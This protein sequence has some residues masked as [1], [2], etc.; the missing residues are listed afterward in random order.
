MERDYYF[1][2]K[3][4]EGE[5]SVAPIITQEQRTLFFDTISSIGTEDVYSSILDGSLFGN[6]GKHPNGAKLTPIR[7]LFDKNGITSDIVIELV[8]EAR[9][10]KLDEFFKAVIS[11]F[12]GDEATEILK[13]FFR[14]DCDTVYGMSNDLRDERG[15]DF[16]HELDWLGLIEPSEVAETVVWRAVRDGVEMIH[17][18]KA[19]HT[20]EEKV[21]IQPGPSEDARAIDAIFAQYGHSLDLSEEVAEEYVYFDVDSYNE[22]VFDAIYTNE[23]R[24]AV[25]YIAQVAKSLG[26]GTKT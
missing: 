4:T 2:R 15:L 12:G 8:H 19:D 20:K 14:D 7:D 24:A 5:K 17:V 9:A 18:N 10:A 22:A 11:A 13:D 3:V 21:V 26:K 16:S 25:Y 23:E 1:I 6:L